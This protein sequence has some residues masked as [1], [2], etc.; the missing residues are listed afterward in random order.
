MKVSVALCTFNGSKHLEAQLNSFLSQLRRPDELVV[1]D[2][3][4]VDR[5][6]E[7]LNSFAGRANFPVR[8]YVSF[9]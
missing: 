5:T 3:G 7:I 9:R 8:I 6:V 2:D 4:S 1:C